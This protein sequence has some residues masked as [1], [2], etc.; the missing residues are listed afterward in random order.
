MN[1]AQPL[2]L[3]DDDMFI[4]SKLDLLAHYERI[5]ERGLDTFVEVGMALLE[6]RDGK[7]YQQKGYKTFEQYCRERF[8][9]ER[10]HAYR[11]MDAAEVVENVSNWTQIVPA[12]E[13]Q[14]RPLTS[15]PRE[16]QPAA[17]QEAVETA[18]NGKVTAAHVQEVVDSRRPMQVHYSS[19]TPEHYTPSDILDAVI[20]CMGAIDLDPCSNS[21]GAPQVP[22]ILH[23]TKSQ[24]GLLQPWFGRVFMNPPYGDEIAKWVD[25]LCSE[26][27]LGNV[28]QAIALVPARTDTDWFDQLINGHR[29]VCYVHGRLK[30]V[31]SEGRAQS[32]APFP[33][34]IVY[35]GN[36]EANFYDAFASFGRICQ[37]VHPEMSFGR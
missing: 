11:L 13:S 9:L 35:F 3:F 1:G 17:W 4:E 6:I 31:G 33:S 19:E 8:Q 7:L 27:A 5:I 2:T 16:E 10:R 21:I 32:S 14:A 29:F 26:E 25:K 15:L 30:F 23:Y 12:T 36:E 28:T 22:A 18:P 24:D 37:E 34:A 20:A